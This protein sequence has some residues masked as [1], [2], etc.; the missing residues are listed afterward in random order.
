MKK[1]HS[2][3]VLAYKESPY[4]EE[5]IKSVLNQKYKSNVVIA[6]STPNNYINAMAKKYKLPLII[7]NSGVKGIGYDFDFAINS[8]DTKLVTIAHQDDIYDYDY[9]QEVIN[10]YN[11]YHDSIII[12]SH[13]YE[14]KN[15]NKICSN[16]N[17][18]IKRILLFPLKIHSISG[19]KFFKRHVIR[20]GN[21]IGCPAV[22]FVKENVPKFIY[23]TNLKCDVDWFAW[24]MLS[25]RKGKFSYISKQLMGHRI[26]ENSTTTDIIHNNIRT[27]EDYE[28]FK[29]FWPRPIAFVINKLYSKS[30]KN[31]QIKDN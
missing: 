10:M 31:N 21:A 7:N 11:K 20:F 25:K 4:L 16:L 22:T 8:V 23:S 15:G 26:H 24:E 14:I 29:K 6:T 9:A 12:F 19:I 2:F 17:L 3:V 30:E 5:C 27:E 18:N 28:I 1:I 13:Y